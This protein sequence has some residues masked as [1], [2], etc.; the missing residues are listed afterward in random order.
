MIYFVYFGKENLK[1]LMKDY[2]SFKSNHMFTFKRNENSI[3][4]LDLNVRLNKG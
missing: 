3:N 1:N 4:F 2:D